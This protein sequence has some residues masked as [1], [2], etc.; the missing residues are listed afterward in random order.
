MIKT[1]EVIGCPSSRR[2]LMETPYTDSPVWFCVDHA[3]Y[4]QNATGKKNGFEV[5]R[6]E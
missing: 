6:R 2:R 3:N 5:V 4:M 1:C